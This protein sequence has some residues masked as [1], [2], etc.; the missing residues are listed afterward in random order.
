MSAAVS[1]GVRLSF[2]EA[3]HCLHPGAMAYRGGPWKSIRFPA[4]VAVLEHPREGV[5]LFDTGY[6]RRFHEQ[7]RNFPNRFYA[8]I[9]PVSVTEEET[10]ISQ[11][12]GR[13]VGVRDVRTVILSHF[14]A[15]HVA[16]A[17]DF[18]HA[19]YVYDG[20][21]YARLEKL[22]AFA[23]LRSGFLRGLLP[24]DFARR[25]RP[26]FP[27][28]RVRTADA[29]PGFFDEAVDLFGDGSILVIA[30]P[31][32][33]AGHVGLLV[34][35]AEGEQVFLI[36]DACWRRESFQ[37]GRP[38]LAVAGMIF[39]DRPEYARTLARLHGLHRTRPEL[40]IVPCHCTATLAELGHS[41]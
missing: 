2:L 5:V 28:E 9:T 17:G 32:H 13:G 11:L 23:G 41:A 31:G 14:H 26:L 24:D 40:K 10:A 20:E 21:G 19:T 15:D 16:G 1:G 7:T 18:P 34:R 37:E 22:S 36:S 29:L 8:L 39:D 30:L 12:A 6:S 35:T 25:G 3:G 33:A 38:P 27:R 4:M